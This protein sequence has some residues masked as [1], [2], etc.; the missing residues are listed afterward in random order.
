MNNLEGYNI[1]KSH[2][3]NANDTTKDFLEIFQIPQTEFQHFRYHFKELSSERSSFRKKGNL[4]DWN[5]TLFSHSE[6][7]YSLSCQ[8]SIPKATENVFIEQSQLPSRKHILT[9]TMESLA[10]RLATLLEH[11]SF[12]ASRESVDLKQIAS[13]TL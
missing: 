1:L 12:V 10:K 2:N 11:I 5:S 4:D 7:E 13:M 3:N 9:I 8:P 6:I